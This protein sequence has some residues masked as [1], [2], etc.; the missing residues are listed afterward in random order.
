MTDAFHN[1]NETLEYSSNATALP[2]NTGYGNITSDPEMDEAE[3]R[4]KYFY[5]S[6]ASIISVAVFSVLILLFLYIKRRRSQDELVIATRRITNIYDIED[7]FNEDDIVSPKESLCPTK[8]VPSIQIETVD[9]DG[10][11]KLEYYT[12]PNNSS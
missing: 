9:D 5:L 7:S 11:V 10:N 1:L 12:G 4:S 8:E 6:L 2:S 3:Q